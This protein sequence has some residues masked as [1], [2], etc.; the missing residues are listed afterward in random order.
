MPVE[1]GFA[2]NDI[3]LPA[4]PPDPA[5]ARSLD[6]LV[7]CLRGLK[8][9]AGDPSFDTITRRINARW[10][11]AGRRA[12]ELARRGTVVDCFKPGR[13]RVNAELMVAVVQALHD[14][15]GYV[16][17]WRQALRD[18]RVGTEAAA[19]V[20]VHDRLPDDLPGFVGRSA[21]LAAVQEPVTV[22]TGMPGA[23]KTALA[24]HAAH[25][26]AADGDFDVTLFADLRGFHP[27]MPPVE[28]AQILDGLRR[29]LAG[30]RAL[31]VLDDAASMRQIAPL[32]PATPG[33]RTLVTSRRR[34]DVA[35]V[36]VEP[37]PPADAR[38]LLTQ[39]VPG[40]PAG[41]D[42]DAYRRVAERCGHLP[43][44]LTHAAGQLAA[45]AGWTVT[46]HADRLDERRLR[47]ELDE[48]IESALH[49]SYQALPPGPQALLRTLAL[50]PAADFD[51]A[52]A[53]A[54][55]G[56]T[57]VTAHLDHLTR[58]HLIRPAGPGRY[59]LHDLVRVYAARRGHDEDRPADRAAARERL[60]AWR[61][62]QR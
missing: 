59:A 54:L 22:F 38:R 41:S 61:F 6:D 47:L 9:W 23:G 45:R 40:V 42:P 60:H 35:Q 21:E 49:P 19:Q 12:D 2:M 10:R 30:R 15:P 46:D 62:A 44:A 25:R 50:H 36:E 58:E 48:R 29:R 39:A 57:P 28:P 5:R 26:L 37:L 20:R 13:R 16:A 18:G 27:A 24:V 52:A 7:G 11:A 14:Y 56:T 4:G 34:L 32:L 43:L 3:A 53:A 55:L 33:S 8:T 1:R 17:R 31:L 51:L